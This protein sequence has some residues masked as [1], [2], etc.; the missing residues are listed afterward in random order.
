MPEVDTILGYADPALDKSDRLLF[1]SCRKVKANAQTGVQLCSNMSTSV[2][3]LG[4]F[5]KF[6]E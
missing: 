1:P 4:G 5:W 2:E 6:M 3:N